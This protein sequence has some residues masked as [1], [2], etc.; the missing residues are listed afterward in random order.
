MLSEIYRDKKLMES[1]IQLKDYFIDKF[2]EDHIINEIIS[3][4]L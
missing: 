3:Y 4:L 1:I 2:K